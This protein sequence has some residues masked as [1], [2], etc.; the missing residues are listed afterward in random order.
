MLR[1][2]EVISKDNSIDRI[3]KNV[4]FVSARS[5]SRAGGVQTFFY[6]MVQFSPPE[7]E[8]TWYCPGSEDKD[9]GEE[10][11]LLGVS[12]VTGELN[13]FQCSQ[14][15]LYHT[16]T[17]D[18]WQ[19]CHKKKY[20]I[21]HVNTGILNFETFVITLARV[22]GIPERIAH[23]HNC[24]PI[25]KTNL[26]NRV[27]HYA[28]QKVLLFN[29]TKLAACSAKAAENLFGL[30]KAQE[31]FI[32]PNGVDISKF[33]FSLKERNI[34]RKD[35]GLDHMFVLG[36]VSVFNKQKN[37]RFLIEVFRMVAER[38]DNARLL[39]VGGGRLKEEI[40]QQ[41]VQFGLSQK[42]VFAGYTDRVGEYLSAMDVFMFPSLYE[43]LGNAVIEAQI[44]GLPCVMSDGVPSE[45]KVT[46]KVLFLSLNQE[47]SEWADQILKINLN[48]IEERARAWEKVSGTRYDCTKLGRF[49]SELY[50]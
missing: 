3:H 12:L 42:V 45:A 17:R 48:S 40:L 1:F 29:A 2:R 9:F 6:N 27:K 28:A 21:I 24:L 39:L 38:K 25:I 11:R 35:L 10:I 30:K 16:V 7:Y 19:L 49:I 33:A 47:P 13:L 43:G 15:E 34:Y 14:E 32:F 23:S 5:V 46:E 31:A 8:Y 18:I 44:S 22:C 41:I 37:H 26:L 20:D 36:T 4:L 50:G